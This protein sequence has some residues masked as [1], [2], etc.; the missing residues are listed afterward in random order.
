MQK[1]TAIKGNVIKTLAMSWLI[2]LCSIWVVCAVPSFV[3]AAEDAASVN[4]TFE[5]LTPEP[6]I[7]IPGL[8]FSTELKQTTVNGEQKLQIPYMAEYFAALYKY[9]IGASLIAAAIMMTYGG[10]LYILGGSIQSISNGKDKIKQALVG[11]ALVFSAVTILNT[12]N[13]NAATV[14][15]L[16]VTLIKPDPINS[17][18]G[19]NQDAPQTMT[20]LGIQPRAKAPTNVAVGAPQTG[21]PA[22][23]Q[24]ANEKPDL[25]ST[26]PT[27]PGGP[28]GTVVG[29]AVATT[30][31]FVPPPS[32]AK[33]PTDLKIPK[34]CPGRNPGFDAP[35]TSN[36]YQAKAK[37]ELDKFVLLGG[38]PIYPK[39]RLAIPLDEAAIEK[40]L[41]E[42]SITG[43]PAGAIIA[44]MLTESWN[45]CV[46]NRLFSDPKSCSTSDFV[47]YL[48][49]G[50]IGCTAAQVPANSCPHVAFY[51]GFNVKDKSDV[52]GKGGCSDGPN[53]FN[54]AAGSNCAS[55]CASSNQNSFNNCGPNCYAQKSHASTVVNGKEVWFPSVQCSRKY[56]SAQEF[57]NSHLGFVKFCLPYNDSVYKFAYCIGASTYA[58]V[59]GDKGA[60]LAEIIERNCLCGS[61]DSTGC[62]R[63]LEFEKQ[64]SLN[65]IKKR[66]LTLYGA[67]CLEYYD[68]AHKKCKK[69]ASYDEGPDYD[70]IIK[71][72]SESTKGA[73]NP[74]EFPQNDVIPPGTQ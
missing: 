74:R 7:S 29:Q 4:A 5:P 15:P 50:G 32:T 66:N 45:T 1:S 65:L 44:Q 22:V 63:D 8:S 38:R 13:P 49:F 19:A 27:T 73:L 31:E 37:G 35:S 12:F 23:A 34:T 40:Y 11:L 17:Y 71:A 55:I 51:P 21:D 68:A 39:T 72:L 3:F 14:K 46:I 69:Y 24:A 6:Q 26:G 61:N 64:L 70:A 28:Q 54:N 48:N 30:D 67:K 16:D 25:S 62:K 9:I 57:L 52:I 42:Q 33:Y 36:P 60:L 18:L 20:E 2:G 41:E 43:V 56:N 58:G 53:N 59:S 10:F 47:K